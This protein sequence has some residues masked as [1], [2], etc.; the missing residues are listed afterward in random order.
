MLPYSRQRQYKQNQAPTTASTSA[1]I[2][3]TIVKIPKVP[4]IVLSEQKSWMVSGELIQ[5]K[6]IQKKHSVTKRDGNPIH[7]ARVDDYW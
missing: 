6:N 3:P 1:K 2:P 5:Q 4:P 7:P